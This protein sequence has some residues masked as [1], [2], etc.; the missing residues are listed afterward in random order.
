MNIDRTAMF[1]VCVAKGQTEARGPSR[2][3]CKARGLI[4]RNRVQGSYDSR[5]P[6]RCASI[7]GVEEL[8]RLHAA[9][10]NDAGLQLCLHQPP[11]S[12]N[13]WPGAGKWPR[14]HDE[15]IIAKCELDDWRS[16]NLVFHTL[17]GLGWTARPH[18]VVSLAPPAPGPDWH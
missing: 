2:P 4:C 6:S 8:W 3:G 13:P 15:R 5:I 18:W 16:G 17:H 7:V 12:Q 10:N 1:A 11:S 9:S 14:V